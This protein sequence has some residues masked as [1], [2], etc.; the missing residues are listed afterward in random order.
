M[1]C[2]AR[3]L[4]HVERTGEPRLVKLEWDEPPPDEHAAAFEEAI[5]TAMSGWSFTPAVRIVGKRQEDGSIEPE[6]TPIP[7]A[8]HA[9]IRF[10]V[11]DGEAIVE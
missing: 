9:F 4:Y 11:E 1:A 5:R 3:I 6:R 8:Q 10:R 7:Q 2:V